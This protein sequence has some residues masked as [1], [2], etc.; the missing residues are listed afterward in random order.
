MLQ[1]RDS[2]CWCRCRVACQRVV[3]GNKFE[4]SASALMQVP[5]SAGDC[6][7]ARSY[8][9]VS[10][11]DHV[12]RL[13]THPSPARPGLEVVE[14]KRKKGGSGGGVY[15]LPVVRSHARPCRSRAMV[16]KREH[17]QQVMEGNNGLH[18]HRMLTVVSYVVAY[19]AMF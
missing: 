10:V 14:R 18:W 15:T 1:R 17:V 8:A 2:D 9:Y 11:K 7:H 16:R 19:I 4:N 3:A 5:S 6:H 12:G 13:K